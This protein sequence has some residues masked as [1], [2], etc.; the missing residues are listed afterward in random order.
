MKGV[1]PFVRAPTTQPDPFLQG[2]PLAPPEPQ[3]SEAVVD[4][5]PSLLLP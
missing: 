1:R 5:D 4:R 3:A 2:P